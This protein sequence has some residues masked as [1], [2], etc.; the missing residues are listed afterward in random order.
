MRI[1]AIEP[2]ES[3]HLSGLRPTGNGLERYVPEPKVF[4]RPLGV[5]GERRPAAG[6]GRTRQDEGRIRM[7][8]RSSSEP[9]STIH[10]VQITHLPP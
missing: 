3:R 1:V 9:P 6:Q 4:G 2:S 7:P 5:V 10:R 8:M